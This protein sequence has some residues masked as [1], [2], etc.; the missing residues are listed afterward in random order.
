MIQT[1]LAP[2]G[3]SRQAIQERCDPN[4]VAPND[5]LAVPPDGDGQHLAAGAEPV[6][7]AQAGRHG[8]PQPSAVGQLVL[9][10]PALQRQVRGQVEGSNLRR[11]AAGLDAG[12]LVEKAA[13]G[14]AAAEQIIGFDQASE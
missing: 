13:V 12:R 11:P 1:S 3:V 14:L 8:D 2:R 10:L 9:G 7:A 6:A 5:H 4:V